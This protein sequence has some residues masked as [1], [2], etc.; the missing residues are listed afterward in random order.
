MER[1]FEY[2]TVIN[3]GARC[4]SVKDIFKAAKGTTSEPSHRGSL[5]LE[6]ENVV[7]PSIRKV[8][9]ARGREGVRAA[10]HQE[11]RWCKR[12]RGC[13]CGLHWKGAGVVKEENEVRVENLLN[14]ECLVARTCH[15]MMHSNS[16]D[17]VL[18]N[19]PTYSFAL[20]ID[21]NWNNK[22][23]LHVLYNMNFLAL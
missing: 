16:I 10:F 4:R 23:F 12:T 11:G 9:G 2:R 7:R 21:K 17:T 18:S 5:V 8:T 13:V 6:C 15:V 22:I 1:S 3:D 19:I 20:V 14:M